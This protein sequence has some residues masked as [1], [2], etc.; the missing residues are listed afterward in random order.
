M[1]TKTFV[2]NAFGSIK[3]IARKERESLFPG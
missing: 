2:E 1:K 3:R